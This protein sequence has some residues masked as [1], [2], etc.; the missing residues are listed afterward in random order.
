MD[1]LKACVNPE[2]CG[3]LTAGDLLTLQLTLK[4]NG[5]P[6]TPLAGATFQ[7]MIPAF[8]GGTLSLPTGSHTIVEDG[9]DEFLNGRVNL[10][11]TAEQ[12]AAV[13][14]GR[15]VQFITVVTLGGQALSFWGE[16]DEVR[17]PFK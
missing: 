11:L 5:E 14:R 12:S 3:Y 17:E 8:Y 9:V 7:T 15:K 16:L 10:A 6:F 2:S 13:K 4:K 1:T